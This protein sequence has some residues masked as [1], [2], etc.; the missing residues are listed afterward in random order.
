LKICQ[1]DAGRPGWLAYFHHRRVR[2]AAP[3]AL[4]TAARSS[5]TESPIAKKGTESNEKV[6]CHLPVFADRST[7]CM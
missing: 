7:G 2:E 1:A 6:D 5:K 3:I 4:V